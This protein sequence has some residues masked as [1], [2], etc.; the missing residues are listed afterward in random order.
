MK[1]S[2]YNQFKLVK[3][4]RPISI[5]HVK[6]LMTSIKQ[7]GYFNSKPITVNKFME[8]SDGQH[9]FMACKELNIPVH[10]EIDDIGVNESMVVLNTTSNVWRLDEF[11]NHY[12]EN[13]I[14][15]YIE[16][17]NLIN[18]TGYGT[19]NC[20]VIYSGSIG[21]AT[22]MIRNGLPIKK[23][24][25][26]TEVVELIEFF[27]GKLKFCLNSQ[28]IKSLVS[29]CNLKEINSRHIEKLKLN[30]YSIQQCATNEQYLI[31]YKK[32]MK[33]K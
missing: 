19:S 28:F 2:D 25:K 32:I 16:L 12:A 5:G 10:Y 4:N 29:L 13:G 17:R 9:R 31:Q 24:D 21:G 14:F 27:K 33:I 18:Q 22:R 3:T 11:I 7:H 15:C 20:I 23:Y 6:K 30:T 26:I 8:I 1:T